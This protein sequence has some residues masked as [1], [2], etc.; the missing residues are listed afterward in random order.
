VDRATFESDRLRLF[1]DNGFSGSSRWV[2]D[3]AGRQTYLLE[4]RGDSRP[5]ILVHGGLTQGGRWCLVAGRLHGPVAIVDRP[6]WG[7][8]YPFDY[9]TA[10]FRTAATEWMKV[11]VD[12]LGADE[13]DLV[14]ASIGGFISAA[15]A[16]QYPTRVRRLIFVGA[17][18][19]LRRSLPIPLR[20]MGNPVVGPLMSRM[21]ITDP[22][23]NRRRVFANLVAHPEDLPIAVLQNDIDA[24]ALDGAGKAAYTMMRSM[25]TIGGFRPTMMI[26]DDLT[27]LTHPTLFL[28]GD[29]DSF[30]PVSVGRNIAD[31][32]PDARIQV[33]P[34]AGHCVELERPEIVAEAI[35]QFLH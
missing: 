10:P 11:V 4:R 19:G 30:V 24:M 6:G 8:S 7:L 23:V 16:L 33:V 27:R 13:V 21:K 9:R 17:P 22:E 26:A 14:G 31:R 3:A 2:D 25:T 5:V 28:W 35:G 18:P 29:A 15:F 1:E 12:A 34:D 32:M 20:L